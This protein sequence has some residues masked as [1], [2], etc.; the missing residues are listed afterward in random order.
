MFGCFFVVGG[1]GCFKFWFV[2]FF[3]EGFFDISFEGLPFDEA[4]VGSVT[5]KDEEGFG[6]FIAL[7]EVG[8]LFCGKG[9]CAVGL[10]EEG[11]VGGVFGSEVSNIFEVGVPYQKTDLVEFFLC[12]VVVGF[13]AVGCEWHGFLGLEIR[14]WK[15]EIILKTG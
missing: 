14:N 11:G 5:D 3:G 4:L 13:W 12:A 8:H 10:S 9:C 6:C 7:L 2:K 15:L 1:A